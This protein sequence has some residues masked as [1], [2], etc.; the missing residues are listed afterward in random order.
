MHGQLRFAPG[1][2]KSDAPPADAGE[3]PWLRYYQQTFSSARLKRKAMARKS[4]RKL[5]EAALISPLFAIASG[6]GAA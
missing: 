6:P 5:P 4:W 1:A 3:Q 2:N